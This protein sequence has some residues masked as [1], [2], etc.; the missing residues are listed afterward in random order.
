MSQECIVRLNAKHCTTVRRERLMK[1]CTNILIYMDIW[2]IYVCNSWQGALANLKN[3]FLNVRQ[4]TMHKVRLVP[5][6][7]GKSA[8]I[9]WWGRNPEEETRYLD[10]TRGKCWTM[11]TKR[12][13]RYA[14]THWTRFIILIFLWLDDGSICQKKEEEEISLD[15][16]FIRFIQNFNGEW[17]NLILLNSLEPRR[18]I[19]LIHK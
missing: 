4:T 17:P 14:K 15:S 2:N 6:M 5:D 3:Y 7:F 11:R 1:Y 13:R 9:S 16:P 12:S 8:R 10:R 18:H 19:W